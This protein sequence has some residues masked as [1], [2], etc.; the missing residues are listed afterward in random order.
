MFFSE[1][2]ELG[3]ISLTAS[4]YFYYIFRYNYCLEVCTDDTAKTVHTLN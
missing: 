2:I 3:P 1:N 4:N